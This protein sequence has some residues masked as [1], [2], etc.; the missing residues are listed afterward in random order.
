MKKFL[1]FAAAAL[2]LSMGFTACDDDDDDDNAFGD[3]TGLS[4]DETAMINKDC[5]SDNVASWGNYM[6]IVAKLLVQDATTLYTNWNTVADGKTVSYADYFKGLPGLDAAQQ[7]A[8]GCY[9]IANEVGESKIGE[10]LSLYEDG[11][12]GKALLAVESWFSWHSRTD[13]SN[14]ILS[15]RN[16]VFGSTDGTESATSL[17]AAVKAVKPEVY[18]SLTTAITG[19]YDAILDIPQPFRNHIN[20]TEAKTAQA[21]CA[22]LGEILSGS[23]KSALA[24]VKDATLRTAV[25]EYVD[26]VVLPT[27]QSLLTKN[28]AL[29]A[30]VTAFQKSPST[31]TFAACATAWLTAREPWETSE[32]FL[33]GPV[34]DL[35][36]DPNMDSWPLDLSGIKNILESG[37]FDDL[38]WNGDYDEESEEI[39]AAQAL[40]GFH[41]LEFL[42]F[43]N[44]Q[45]R[46][47]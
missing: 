31:L 8:D 9:D 15:I 3:T 27:Y 40:R 39:E 10:P 17:A 36:L 46:T 22:A 14:N 44:G 32:A 4:A 19:A 33:F 24:D 26:N 12:P 16:S 29:L 13:Y 18:D 45:A 2:C 30:A 47:Y 38:N 25:A 5:T 41:T 28:T 7:I 37:K 11:K 6:N 21:K 42:I 1:T 20:S 23:F 43:K 34:G 35:G